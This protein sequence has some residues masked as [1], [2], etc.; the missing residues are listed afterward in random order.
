[1]DGTPVSVAQLARMA[2]CSAPAVTEALFPAYM[3]GELEFNVRA[4]TFAAKKQGGAL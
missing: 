2:A 4:D 3:D 1:M